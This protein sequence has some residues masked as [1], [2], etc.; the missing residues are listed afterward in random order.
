MDEKTDGRTDG[1]T[2]YR[3]PISHLAKAGVTKIKIQKEEI[4]IRIKHLN[5]TSLPHPLTTTPTQDNI[6]K[7]KRGH[8]RI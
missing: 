5:Y 3:T 4:K 6:K 1:R 7:R 8:Q 2:E